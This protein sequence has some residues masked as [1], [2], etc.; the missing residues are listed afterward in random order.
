M[1][2][3]VVNGEVRQAPDNGHLLDMLRHLEIDPSRVA[4]ELDRQIV[5]KSDWERTPVRAGAQLEIVQFVGG[6]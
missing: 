3:I 6:G 4:I 1:I 2:E 5:R